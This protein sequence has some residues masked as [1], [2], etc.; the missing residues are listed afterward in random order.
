MVSALK[1]DLVMTTSQWRPNVQLK[2]N[3]AVENMEVP[4]IVQ[5]EKETS[6]DTIKHLSWDALL[7]ENDLGLPYQYGY[8]ST[9]TTITYD[10]SSDHEN[11]GK[12]ITD[13][14]KNQVTTL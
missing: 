14:K 6:Q 1:S 8:I 9:A 11:I 5:M 2:G 7:M 10:T 12:T 3:P 4:N 13:M